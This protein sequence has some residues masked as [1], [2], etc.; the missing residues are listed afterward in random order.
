PTPA[1]RPLN[2]RLDTTKLRNTFDLYLPD[3]QDGVLRTLSEILV[4][5]RS[6]V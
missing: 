6:R 2:S 5:R 1:V 4:N 3:W